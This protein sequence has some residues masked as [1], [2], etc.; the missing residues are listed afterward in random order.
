MLGGIGG[1]RR[2]G[3]QRKRW[4]DG[5]TDSTDM[6]L[7][8]LRELVM[9]REAWRAAF[10]ASQR[11]RHDWATE[12]NWSWTSQLAQRVKRLPAVQEIWVLSLGWEDP[13]EKE[14][15]IHPR[16]LTWRIPWTEEP[17]GLKPSMGRRVGHDWVN[18]TQVSLTGLKPRCWQSEFLLENPSGNLFL[19]FSSS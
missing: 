10:M 14:M 8:E 18:T 11:V 15:V 2:R 7:G 19:A 16:V 5:I 17:G 13:L 4:L 1:R 12:L 3:W 9:D 6:S